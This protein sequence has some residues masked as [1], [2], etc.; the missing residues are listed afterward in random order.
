MERCLYNEGF[1]GLCPDCIIYGYAIGD[2]G[3]EKSKVYVDT[4]YS[5]TSYDESHESLTL[6]APYEDGTMTKGGATTPRFSEQDHVKPEVYFPAVV[7][8]RDPTPHTLAY[9]LNNLRRTRLYGAQTTRTGHVENSVLALIFADGEI[10]SNLRL[11]Q[12][13]ADRWDGQNGHELIR[14]AVLE[15]ARELIR[16]D[17]VVYELVEG[18]MLETIAGELHSTFIDPIRLEDFMRALAEECYAYADRIG[19]VKAAKKGKGK[20]STE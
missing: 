9:V 5:L 12:V 11:V 15:A 8:V 20:G 3:S 1:C 7:T 14:K 16:H 18:E 19:V 2:T 6:N 13:T 17:G 10:F 4:A